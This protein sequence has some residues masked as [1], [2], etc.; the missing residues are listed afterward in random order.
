MLAL[1]NNASAT[2]SLGGPLVPVRPGETGTAK[3]D[4]FFD[5]TEHTGDKGEPAG[6]TCHV[7]FARDLF[8]PGTARVLAEG[9]VEVLGRAA[10]DPQR[11]LEELVPE[12][13]LARRAVEPGP[14]AP[15][16]E[17]EDRLRAMSGACSATR[18]R[19]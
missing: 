8:D 11:R 17:L 16:S 12:G 5:I 19:G 15:T 4:L 2:V 13:L 3:F 18:H 6:L 1:Q 7:E 14:D 10:A 9:L